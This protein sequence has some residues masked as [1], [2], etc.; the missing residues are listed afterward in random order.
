MW[1]FFHDIVFGLTALQHR[2]QDAAGIATFDTN[3]H[4]HKAQ[5]HPLARHQPAVDSRIFA[6]KV[7]VLKH[8]E[9]LGH[10]VGVFVVNLEVF[11]NKYRLTGADVLYEIKA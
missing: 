2:G 11:I 3:F 7:N 10:I 1:L 8:A 6:G 9:R 4:L 5:A